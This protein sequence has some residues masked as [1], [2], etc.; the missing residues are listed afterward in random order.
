LVDCS[1]GNSQKDY[2]RQPLVAEDVAAQLE[3][4]SDVIL[5]VMLE[6]H[7][8]AGRQDL[9][10]GRALCYGQSITDACVDLATTERVLE[11]LAHAARKRRMANAM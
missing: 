3:R 10:A 5:G 1:H 11:R 7:L 2:A 9:V 6:S 4:G 8:V